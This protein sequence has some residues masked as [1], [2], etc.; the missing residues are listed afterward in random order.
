LSLISFSFAEVPSNAQ[1]E[2]VYRKNPN[3]IYDAYRKLYVVE[4]AVPVL[5]FPELT[6][7]K[8]ED[9]LIIDYVGLGLIRIGD[10]HRFLQYDFKMKPVVK[11][12][13][14]DSGFAAS[15]VWYVVGVV[16]LLLAG[17]AGGVYVSN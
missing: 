12:G 11:A 17:F 9:K 3:A 1:I 13:I 5:N 4:R 7:L 15:P 8:S 14:K 2:S 6:V 10:E 16:S